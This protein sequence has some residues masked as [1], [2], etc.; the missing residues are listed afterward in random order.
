M[1]IVVIGAGGRLGHEVA[2]HLAGAHTVTGFWHQDLGLENNAAIRER[3]AGESFDVLINTAAMTG[4]DACETQQ[5]L[6]MQVN[7]AAPGEMAK[8]CAERGARFIHISTDYVFD[9]EQE[10]ELD[11]SVQ[12][13]PVSIYG[14]SKL[15]GERQVLEVE[16]N[17]L[18]ARVSWVFGKHRPS[19]IDMIAER[20]MNFERVEAIGDKFSCPTAASDC[21][22]WL[23]ALLDRRDV[24]GVIHLCNRGGTTW[25]EY[26]Q[27]A[28]EMGAEKYGIPFKTTKVEFIPIASMT[29]FI[30]KRPVHTVMATH[31]LE[32]VL[33]HAPAHWREAVEAY[34]ATV[35]QP[36]HT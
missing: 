29:N 17:N 2:E 34:V 3:L 27:Y 21:A 13:R 19:F 35:L 6:A 32:K 7:G 14:E 9:G 15:E 11:E 10:G 22:K 4:V 30:A 24:T 36:R 28:L 33:G 25:Q 23:K 8:I 1:K 5:E 16:G 26:G 31:R 18:V 12:P 20:A